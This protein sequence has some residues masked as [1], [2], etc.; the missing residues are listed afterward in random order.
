MNHK[1]SL[2]LVALLIV[3][4]VFS[5][6]AFAEEGAP[7]ANTPIQVISSTLERSGGGLSMIPM[8]S[9]MTF[10]T[11]NVTDSSGQLN[12]AP[13]NLMHYNLTYIIAEPHDYLIKLVLTGPDGAVERENTLPLGGVEG[14]NSFA[15][16]ML[17][18]SGAQGEYI[19]ELYI[20]G[21]LSDT[22]TFTD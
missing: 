15:A 17:A 4:T 6:P 12:S 21:I 20:D 16:I 7:L 18:A 3:A 8:D 2:M 14:E 10:L 5:L 19:A 1:I 22:A 9:A 11:N 13:D